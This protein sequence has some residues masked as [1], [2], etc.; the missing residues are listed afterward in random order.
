MAY[1]PTAEAGALATRED[2]ER[3]FSLVRSDIAGVKHDIRRMKDDRGDERRPAGDEGRIRHL[4]QRVD[5]IQHTLLAGFLSM[6]VALM[7]AVR[8]G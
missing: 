5:K 8:L 1:L 7:V 4:A 3:E 6:V 2:L